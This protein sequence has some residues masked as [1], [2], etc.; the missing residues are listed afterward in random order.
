M[1][2][3]IP[4]GTRDVLP[5]EMRE[6]RRLQTALLDVFERLR[7]QRGPDTDASNTP[8]WSIADDDARLRPTGS[9]TTAANCWRCAPT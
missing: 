4:P 3:P 5:D 8:T 6:L 1:I 2:H 9:S 7:L